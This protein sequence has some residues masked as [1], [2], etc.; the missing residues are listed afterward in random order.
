MTGVYCAVVVALVACCL[1]AVVAAAHPS[2][3][4]K[5]LSRT[6]GCESEDSCSIDYHRSSRGP[7]WVIRT[8]RP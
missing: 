8:Q 2:T 6:Y 5:V 4:G 1:L 7:V 3:E